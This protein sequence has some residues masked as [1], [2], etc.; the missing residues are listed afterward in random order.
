MGLWDWLRSLFGAKEDVSVMMERAAAPVLRKFAEE[1]GCAV[2]VV[3]VHPTRVVFLFT[4][5]RGRF[6]QAT[7]IAADMRKGAFV[8]GMIPSQEAAPSVKETQAV[9]M[10]WFKKVRSEP[11]L[12]TA[13]ENQEKKIKAALINAQMNVDALEEMREMK[14]LVRRGRKNDKGKK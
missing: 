14:D 6:V 13:I 10:L 12:V 8:L 5:A 3:E 9:R 11:E 4:V 2:K 1:T 7:L